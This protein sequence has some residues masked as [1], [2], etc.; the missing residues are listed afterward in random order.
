MGVR[1]GHGLPVA[2]PGRRYWQ[3]VGIRAPSISCRALFR[4][5]RYRTRL[6]NVEDR[7]QYLLR[8]SI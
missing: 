8:L 4:L 1:S 7:S 5:V 3:P 2:R 6:D